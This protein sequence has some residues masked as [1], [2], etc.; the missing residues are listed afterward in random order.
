MDQTARQNAN[1][2]TTERN[3]RMKNLK[4]NNPLNLHIQFRHMKPSSSIEQVIQDHAAKLPRF[5]AQTG[6]CTV[7]IDETHHWNKGGQY[8]ISVQ[9]KIPGQKLLVVTVREESTLQDHLHAATHQAFEELARQLKKQKNKARRH[10][11]DRLAA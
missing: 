3:T 8:S 9:L 11:A 4:T 2:A 1:H 7:V 6:S 10:S 5:G